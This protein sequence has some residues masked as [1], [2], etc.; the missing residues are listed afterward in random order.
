MRKFFVA[1]AVAAAC[2]LPA[3]MAQAGPY[4]QAL[5]KCITTH[6]SDQDRLGFVVWI[7]D[8]MSVHPAVKAQ[9]NIS[10]AQRDAATKQA[11]ELMQRL[12]TVDCH[13]EMAGALKFEGLNSIQV[14]FQSLGEVAMQGL[15]TDPG[16]NKQMEDLTHYIDQS[17]FEAVAKEA[18]A[19]KDKP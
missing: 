6:T 14:A 12:M 4:G 9:T 7:F 2:W 18:A 3:S 19:M 13:T 16:V 5:A 11:A 15:M 1:A 10:Q 17:K 8:A